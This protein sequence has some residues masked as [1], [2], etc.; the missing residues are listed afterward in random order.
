L[1][2]CIKVLQTS[3]LATWVRR[4]LEKER[5]RSK[6]YAPSGKLPFFLL[7]DCSLP[8]TVYYH[9]AGNGIR[10]RDPNLGKVVLYQLSYSRIAITKSYRSCEDNP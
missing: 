5:S 3:P 7:T 1:N 2:R 4:P 9:G 6:E 10:T 8:L